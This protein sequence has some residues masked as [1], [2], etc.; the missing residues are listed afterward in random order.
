MTVDFTQISKWIT[1]LLR[2]I[3]W[4]LIT[5]Y[6]RVTI[7]HADRIPRGVPIILT[8]TH[9]SMLDSLFIT[10]L[11][12]GPVHYLVNEGNFHGFQ[13]WLLRKMACIS[14]NLAH[15]SHHAM[16]Q[17]TAIVEAGKPLVIFPE[18]TIYYYPPNQVHVPLT[19]GAAWVSLLVAKEIAPGAPVIVPI[20]LNYSDLQLKFRSRVEVV[21]QPPIDTGPYCELPKKEARQQL[22][23]RIQRELGDI[24]NDSRVEEFPAT[25]FLRQH[26]RKIM[27][28]DA[29]AD[30]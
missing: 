2:P 5:F 29:S 30:P 16:R 3:H 6:F 20:R 11:M 10:Q 1:L 17:C 13:G 12:G 8:P 25:E 23:E 4:L 9:R 22:T 21:V 15:P 7:C 26:G 28:W 24:A 19:P 18:A 14:I 27:S